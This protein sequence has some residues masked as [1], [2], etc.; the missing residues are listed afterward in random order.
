MLTSEELLDK[1][2]IEDITEIL[3]SMGSSKPKKDKNGD[4]YFTTICHGG[5]SHKLHCFVNSKFFMCYTDCGSMSL[6]NLLMNINDWTFK[7]SFNYLAHYKHINI[8]QKKVGLHRRGYE[9]DDEIDF[10]D[11]HLYIPKSNKVNLPV[12][13]DFV[14][15][16][17]DKY[18]PDSWINEGIREEI[19]DY[20]NVRF[21]FNQLKA[22]IPHYD[23]NGHLV[24]IKSRNF[25]QSEI[26]AGRRYMPITIQGLTYKYPVQFNLYGLYQNQIAIKK[27]RKAIIFES[28]KSVFKY[29]SYYGQENNITV[30][31]Q[32][33]NVSLYQRDLLLDMGV[34]D[35]II[36]YDKQYMI[37]YIDDKFR[38]TNEYKDYIMYLKKIYKIV[39]LFINY[40]NVCVML[41]WDDR[42]AYKDSPIDCGKDIFE[43]LHRERYLIEDLNEI[44]EMI[45]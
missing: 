20:F 19:L 22:I 21:Y 42:I 4:L 16:I 25:L 45:N 40:C 7:E 35:L 24:G 9:I 15:N 34:E 31:T 41:C 29:A 12:Y 10:L 11:K 13:N 2:S 28:E 14:L 1:I 8:Y 6:Y 27:S 30:A 44:K 26:D 37:E 38:G 17:F 5:N 33:M 3:I 23:I 43:E 32:G 39:S 18:Y 36:A